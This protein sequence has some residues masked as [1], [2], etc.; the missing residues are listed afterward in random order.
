LVST[1]CPINISSPMVR[2]AAFIVLEFTQKKSSNT[3]SFFYS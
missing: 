1:I 2:I 3:S